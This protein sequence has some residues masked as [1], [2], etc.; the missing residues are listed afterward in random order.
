[1]TDKQKGDQSHKLFK[2]WTSQ[3]LNKQG[4]YHLVGGTGQTEPPPSQEGL[5]STS[6]LKGKKSEQRKWENQLKIR[7]FKNFKSRSKSR[8]C[9]KIYCHN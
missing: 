1:M 2:K 7:N 9:L 6:K 4:E 3:E 8:G 5:M